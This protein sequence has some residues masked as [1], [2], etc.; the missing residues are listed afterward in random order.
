MVTRLHGVDVSGYQ[1]DYAPVSTDAF[2]FVKATEGRTYTSPY[3]AAQAARARA[4]GQVVGFYHYMWPLNA[5]EQAAYFVQQ[6]KPQPGDLLVC[7]WEKAGTS[8][9]DKDA[10]IKA[11]KQLA[12]QCRVGLYCNTNWW[13]NH[14]TTS[15]YG[16]FLWIAD[17]RKAEPPIKTAWTFWQ[18]TQ[19][20]L[21]QNWAQFAS[22][23]ELVT[24]ARGLIPP[25]PSPP[26]PQSA[27][28]TMLD[29]NL[30][31]PQF[32]H[33]NTT[34]SGSKRIP[35]LGDV[36]KRSGATIVSTHEGDR[37]FCAKLSAVLG[38]RWHYQRAQGKGGNGLNAVFWRDEWAIDGKPREWNLDSFGQ[39]QRTLIL[40][41]LVHKDGGYTWAGSTHFAATAPDLPAAAANRAK[42][43]QVKQVCEVLADYR[44]IALGCDLPRT[45]ATDDDAWLR[46][47]GW[48]LT[49]RDSK[50]PEL[51]I[52]KSRVKPIAAKV[53]PTGKAC[54]H[55]ARLL[56]FTTPK[57]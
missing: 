13:L 30:E 8:N 4:A 10:F 1:P 47:H 26:I 17:Y 51:V 43:A 48:T 42:L 7:D 21:D 45:D 57:G 39:W 18:Y 55:D 3:A 14:D 34:L 16:D 33:D 54:D 40:C 28:R 37:D 29:I 35:L 36:I 6:A 31:L 44:Q 53:V 5:A 52:T 20:P 25:P 50:T 38:S 49:G 46:A 15:Y 11:V 12:P 41:R 56:T 24:W 32:V 2:L 27:V 19:D 9:A 23:T 22:K